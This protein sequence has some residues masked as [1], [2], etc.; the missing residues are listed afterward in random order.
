MAIFGAAR[1]V[2][3]ECARLRVFFPFLFF[4]FL[5][6]FSFFLS[7]FSFL[8]SVQCGRE[9]TQIPHAIASK[10]STPR[11]HRIH[12]GEGLSS[13]CAELRV[14][15]FLG[16]AAPSHGISRPH[17]AP[18]TTPLVALGRCGCWAVGRLVL[19]AQPTFFMSP[20]GPPT[21]RFSPW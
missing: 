7:L 13:R 10:H 14:P 12:V 19:A 3:V 5:L 8:A 20:P 4:F 9:R 15:Q 18:P 11:A 1:V 17:C 6:F 16:L 21:P 2:P